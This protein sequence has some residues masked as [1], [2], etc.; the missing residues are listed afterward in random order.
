MSNVV[1]IGD[2]Y[3][4]SGHPVYKIAEIGINHNGD[5]DIAKKLIDSAV[6]A[7]F[8]AVKFQKRTPDLCVPDDQ[9]DV[10]RDTPWGRV[11]Y[12]E[13]RHRVE[14]NQPQYKE[15]DVYCRERN[16]R[17]FTSCWD[18]TAVEFMKQFSP[19]C[20]K[21]ASACLTDD[22][23]ILYVKSLNRPVIL[24]TG[25]STL[26]EI[27]HA[28]SLLGQDNLLIAHS[29]SSYPCRLD[30]L[31][32]RMIN[33][34]KGMYDIPVGYSGHE[35]GFSPTCSAVAMGAH[36]IERHITL[37]KSMWGSDHKASLE[38]HELKDLSEKID[39]VQLSLGD[40]VKKVYDSEK[41]IIEKL[42]VKAVLN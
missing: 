1:K 23:S 12:L 26:D 14:F 30:E 28:V 22:R 37:D 27:K 17:W 5:L 31:N 11:T 18:V 41:P 40:G 10:M 33:T 19:V 25:M 24:S 16:I 20:F 35:N 21:I 36:F 6:D 42:R 34:L 38:P 3:I 9:K 2:Q 29:T 39:D 32:L 13:Y 7:G 15:I 4:G 8:H